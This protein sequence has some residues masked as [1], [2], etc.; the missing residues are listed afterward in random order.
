M[1]LTN[2]NDNHW[3][4]IYQL[5]QINESQ[6][7]DNHNLEFSPQLLGSRQR[8]LTYPSSPLYTM[9]ERDQNS[10]SEVQYYDDQL[11]ELQQ[12]CLRT[13]TEK[14]ESCCCKDENHHQQKHLI[15]KSIR[16]NKSNGKPNWDSSIRKNFPK[17]L[18]NHFLAHLE[19][20][21]DQILPPPITQFLLEFHQIKESK[22]QLSFAISDFSKLCLASEESKKFFIDF[23]Q[24]KL[25]VRL[26]HS[27]K[28]TKIKHVLDLVRNA[29]VGACNPER[30]KGNMQ[31]AKPE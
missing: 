10:D 27:N 24:N 7:F 2:H 31:I 30:W 5:G 23:L 19:Q 20:I 14:S 6:S 17:L 13:E 15:Q 26:I 1:N 28:F 29:Y 9:V 3:Q 18:G 8:T 21:S 12:C 4:E 11:N 22:K 25:P 16:K